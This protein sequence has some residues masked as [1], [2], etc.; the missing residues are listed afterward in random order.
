MAREEVL[1]EFGDFLVTIRNQQGKS[2]KGIELY[3]KNK[4]V[5][6]PKSSLQH[7]EKGKVGAIDSGRLQAIAV[8]YGRS[9]EEIVNRYV[10]ARFGVDLLN[11][12]LR[13][14]LI[15]P[16]EEHA[17]LH[18]KLQMVLECNDERLSVTA[19]TNIE[20]LHMR[21]SSEQELGTSTLARKQELGDSAIQK[22]AVA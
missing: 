3:A 22:A 19:G 21:L 8:V 9:Y 1:K 18:R 6:L 16:N 10:M 2:L 4:D 20:S 15:Y 13:E 17:M 14:E 11:P 7:Y 5:D 12:S